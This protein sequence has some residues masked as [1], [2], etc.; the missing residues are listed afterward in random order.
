MFSW[1]VGQFTSSHRYMDRTLIREGAHTAGV[2]R[3]TAGVGL[4]KCRTPGAGQ[5]VTTWH[6]RQT[7]LIDMT[8]QCLKQSCCPAMR[9]GTENGHPSCPCTFSIL[10]T[11]DS[12][13]GPLA[14]R[15]CC[16]GC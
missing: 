10:S 15:G 8:M 2:G 9:K 6:G 7:V 1:G 13:S 16:W 14:P 3:G 11:V 5:V 4:C 12:L